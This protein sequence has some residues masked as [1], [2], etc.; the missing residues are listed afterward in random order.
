MMSIGTKIRKLR[1][2]NN[3]MSQEELAYKLGIAQ[4]SISNIEAD[5]N[6][7]DFLLMEKICNLFNVDLDYFSENRIENCISKKNDANKSSGEIENPN[8]NRPEGILEN[9]IKRLEKLETLI[10]GYK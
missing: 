8:N 5:K 6:I 3:K 4:T 10:K 7:P 9:I 2:D 1:Q